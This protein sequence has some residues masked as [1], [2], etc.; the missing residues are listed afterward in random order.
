MK[1]NIKALGAIILSAVL[2]TS[3]CALEEG[4]PKATEYVNDKDENDAASDEVSDAASTSD[5]NIIVVEDLFEPI[6]EEIEAALASSEDA[7]ASA[8]ASA[9]SSEEPA[10][11]KEEKEEDKIEMV[12]IGDS[13]MANGRNDGTDLASL[14]SARV[15]GSVAYNIG[16]GGSTAA[17][18][19][20]T[21][22]LDLESWTS[23]CFVGVAYALAG[24][25]NKDTVFSTN[26]EVVEIMNKIDPAKV[27]YYFIEYGANDF[28]NKIALDNVN[29]NSEIPYLHT[30]YGALNTGIDE[31]RRI[32]P[33]AKVILMSP[34]YGIYKDSNGNFIGDT[35]VVSNGIDTLAN[36]ARKSVNVCEVEDIYDFDCMFFTKCD[37][38]LDTYEEYLMDGLHLSLK[39]RQVFARLLA[40][41]PNWLEGYEPFAYMET[42]FIKIADFDPDEY[43]RY[44]KDWMQEYY[45]DNYERMQNGEYLL[46]PP[47]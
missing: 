33:N 25:V 22:N 1:K 35:Y 20:T 43:Y 40:H 36:Y 32:S 14:V 45:P 34:F 13:Q 9:S 38:Y 37:L 41:I 27:D 6:L 44:N 15:P 8:S 19:N 28:F 2:F 21:S 17:V 26:P 30:F 12:F 42:D 46:A 39:G 3:G 23:N 24:K 29:E 11:I 4:A 10:E 5:S 7:S 18:E 47:Q 31:L 16:I